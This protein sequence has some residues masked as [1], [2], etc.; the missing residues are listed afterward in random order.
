M[1]N[2]FITLALLFSVSPV[3]TTSIN[4][5]NGKLDLLEYIDDYKKALRTIV[6]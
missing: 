3:T 1:F 2:A 5:L 6:Y 4:S